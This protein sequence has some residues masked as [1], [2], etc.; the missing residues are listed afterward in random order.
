MTSRTL[1]LLSVL[2]AAST[3]TMAQSPLNSERQP[4]QA[5]PPS[6]SSPAPGKPS[7]KAATPTVTPP[8]APPGREG[9][10]LNIKV[11]VTITDQSGATQALK[12]T[13]TVVSGDQRTSFIRT[14]A[15]YDPPI[16]PVPLNVDVEPQLLSDNRIR[17][18]LNL[19][20]NLPSSEGRAAGAPGVPPVPPLRTTGIQENL[21]MILESG[22]PL[23]VAQS[24]DPVG[25]RQV[26]IEARA[27]VLR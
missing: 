23:I 3:I 17:L 27:T 9:Q 25:D 18:R 24:A 8:P 26:T 7:Q 16:G 5:Q 1:V 14:T 11:E 6:T 19:Q 10:P 4:Q 13:V 22:K 15:Y 21:S 2:I 12:K 20:Y